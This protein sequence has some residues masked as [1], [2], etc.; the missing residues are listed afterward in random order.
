[1]PVVGDQRVRGVLFAGRPQRFRRR[2]RLKQGRAGTFDGVGDLR[3]R[4]W[5][6]AG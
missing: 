5:I 2:G 1:M 4:V 6:A 3:V